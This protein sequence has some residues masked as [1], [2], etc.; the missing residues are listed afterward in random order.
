MVKTPH[1]QCRGKGSLPVEELRSHMPYGAAK[2]R[3]KKKNP[4]HYSLI[5]CIPVI[6]WHLS[7]SSLWPRDHCHNTASLPDRLLTSFPCPDAYNPSSSKIQLQGHA[8]DWRREQL[9]NS[10]ILAWR[11]PLAVQSM[12]SQSQTRLSDFHFTTSWYHLLTIMAT[13]VLMSLNTPSS[14]QAQHWFYLECSSS[15]KLPS[16]HFRSQMYLLKP[17]IPP[18]R[19]M[20]EQ[21][22]SSHYYILY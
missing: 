19:V 16:L 11:I 17:F 18:L 4:I 2:T 22:I 7:P 3:K 8:L 15:L 20:K 1:F 5:G 13:L 10:S 14:L 6:N 12:G 21:P 9:P